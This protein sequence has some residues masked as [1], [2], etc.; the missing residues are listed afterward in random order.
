MTANKK[1][2]LVTLAGGGFLWET[3]SLIKGMG[4]GYEYH[5]ATGADLVWKAKRMGIPEDHIHPIGGGTSLIEKNPLKRS[6]HMLIS[7]R[8]SY[9]VV[10]RVKPYALVCVGTSISV[11]LCFWGKIFRKK[12]IFIE[13]MTRVKKLSLTGRIISVLG[14]YDRFYVQWPE[15]TILQKQAIY[16]GTVL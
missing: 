2:I 16:K 13:S 9:K 7:F 15:S 12:T 1:I 4:D 11:P 6:Q 14:L 3:Q 10:K 8:D 5:Y